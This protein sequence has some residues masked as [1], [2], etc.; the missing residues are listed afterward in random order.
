MSEF[1]PIRG[2]PDRK[3]TLTVVSLRLF[4]EL[5]LVDV[6]LPLGHCADVCRLHSRYQHKHTSPALA[7]RTRQP[8]IWPRLA[9]IL[10]LAPPPS[11]DSPLSRSRSGPRA[12]HDVRRGRKRK[13]T[14]HFLRPAFEP[15]DFPYPSTGAIRSDAELLAFSIPS[16][17]AT[18]KL[19]YGTHFQFVL[20]TN[21]QRL[22]PRRARIC[23]CWGAATAGRKRDPNAFGYFRHLKH[24]YLTSTKSSSLGLISF[25]PF[26]NALVGKFSVFFDTLSVGNIAVD[27]RVLCY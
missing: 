2:R 7:L 12:G 22:F 6:I 1:F 24:L 25:S 18:T 14:K 27:Y 10:S 11:R 8:T 26:L 17:T 4:G 15:T 23:E 16:A 19:H 5:R 13:R 20:E 3:N 9:A 21:D